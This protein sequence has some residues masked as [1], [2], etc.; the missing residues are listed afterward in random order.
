MADPKKRTPKPERQP[1][2][3][4]DAIDKPVPLGPGPD[5]QPDPDKAPQPPDLPGG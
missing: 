4:P 5:P 2:E 1:E 3:N